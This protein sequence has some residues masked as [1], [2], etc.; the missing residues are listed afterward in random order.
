MVRIYDKFIHSVYAY[1]TGE[2]L[3]NPRAV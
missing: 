3:W 1:Y 2:S